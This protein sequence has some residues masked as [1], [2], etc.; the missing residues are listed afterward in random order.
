MTLKIHYYL[1]LFM[2]YLYVINKLEYFF[3]FYIFAIIHEI[4]H[5]MMA[6]ILRVKV[7]EVVMLSIGVN[8]CY[9]EN[10]SHIKEILIAIAGP[11][12]S[13]LLATFLPYSKYSVMNIII[14]FTN[15]IPIYPLD[16]G[17]I[18]RIALIKLMGYKKGIK[19]YGIFL[20]ILVCFLIVV[21]II[22]TVYFKNYY[23]LFFCIYVFLLVDKEIKK[24]RIRL[25]VNELI[26]TQL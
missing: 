1:V 18:L 14:F 4:A 8:A 21:T 7:K 13:L 17:R 20:K 6:T 19:I 9:E 25:V 26:G 24:E 5:I 11:I 10:I 22:F 2:L 15:S 23:F 16:G 12:A 3:V